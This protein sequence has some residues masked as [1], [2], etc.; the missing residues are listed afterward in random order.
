MHASLAELLENLRPGMLWVAK[1]GLVRY[2]NADAGVR[3]GLSTGRRLFDPDM[4]RAV[5]ASVVDKQPREVKA[6][7]LAA[8]PGKGP[9]ELNCRVIPGLAADDAFVLISPQGGKEQGAGFDNLMQ[10]IRSDVSEPLRKAQRALANNATRASGS[11]EEATLA[12]DLGELLTVVDRLVELSSLWSSSA[13]L[14]TDRIE[15]WPMLQKAW[16]AVEPL[17]TQRRVRVRFLAKNNTSDLSALYGSEHWLGRVFQECLEAAV[18]STRADGQI[19][20]EHNQL[21]PRAIVVF[22]DC[23]VFIGREARDAG[24]AMPEAAKSDKTEKARNAT[25]ADLAAPTKA[26]ARELIGLKLCQHIVSLHGGE[27]REESLDG[28]S[29]FI[30][31][32]PTGAPHRSDEQAMDIAQAQRYASD[33]AALMSRS[34]RKAAATAAAAIPSTPAAPAAPAAAPAAVPAA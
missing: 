11:A 21:G 27:L 23:G 16:A 1:D 14:A 19:D 32:L 13:L 4:S 10:A 18:R 7:G 6:V 25:K 34:R 29:N 28:L 24:V 30:I 9:S 31:D 8:G 5:A 26:G 22:K 2:A 20:I 33:L 12:Q 15:L 17:A 3:T